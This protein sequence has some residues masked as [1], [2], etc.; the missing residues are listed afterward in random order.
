MN[1]RRTD[2][3]FGW[4]TRIWDFI[5]NRDIDKHAVSL[6]VL[7][8]TY[9]L[10]EWAMLYVSTCKDKSGVEI[11]AII[12]AVTAPYMALQAAAIKFYFD[13]RGKQ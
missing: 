7:W 10:T 8:G 13:A 6:M 2:G 11:A 12:A 1:R 4:M 9:K 3:W 5:D